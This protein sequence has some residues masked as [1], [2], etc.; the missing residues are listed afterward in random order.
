MI[1]IIV[2]DYKSIEKTLQYLRNAYEGMLDSESLHG[3]IVDNNYG[4]TKGLEILQNTI[5]TPI[6]K[7]CIDK[8]L[9]QIEGSYVDSVYMC[10]FYGRKLVYIHSLENLG[11]GK[12]NNL[13]AQIGSLLFSDKYYI[14][15]NNDIRFLEKFSIAQLIK[16]FRTEKNIAVI[17]P[18]IIDRN[19]VQ[20]NPR[21]HKSAFEVLF[22]YYDSLLLPKKLQNEK[23]SSDVDITHK[24]KVCSWVSGSFM[25][26]DAMKFWECGGFD[27]HTFL[28]AE[29]LILAKK[30]EEHQYCMYY[31]NK[32]T[33]VHE[34]G[35]TVNNTMSI[36]ESIRTSFKALLYYYETYKKLSPL[37]SILARGHF[38]VFCMLF[39]LKKGIGRMI[40]KDDQ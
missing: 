8:S 18:K 38:Q 15:S 7:I 2:V 34:H 20:Q 17:G 28:Y 23:Y 21:K 1:S 13:G 32:M 10:E 30:M 9:T 27:P 29:E 25:A 5:L 3:I 19:G 6:E 11:Y 14:F 26:V 12:G 22:I 4:S 40:F 33:L 36:I 31:L 35:Q 16:P 24:S 37:V 39:A